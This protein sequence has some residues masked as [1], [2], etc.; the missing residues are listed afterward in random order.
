MFPTNDGGMSTAQAFAVVTRP[1][2]TMALQYLFRRS[3]S[4][5]AKKHSEHPL[6]R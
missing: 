1:V 4:V 3:P 6:R 5:V 2:Y